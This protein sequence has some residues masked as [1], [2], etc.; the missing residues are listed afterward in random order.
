[1]II[2]ANAGL[3]M[4]LVVGPALVVALLPIV[5][6][7]AGIYRRRI[8]VPWGRAVCGSLG[9]NLLSTFVGVPLTWAVLLGLQFVTG[10]D[11]SGSGV[12]IHS[13]TWQAPWL[14]PYE[15]HLH[16]MIPTAAIVLCVP[17]LLASVLVENLFLRRIWQEQAS[18]TILRACWIANGLTYGCLVAFWGVQLILAISR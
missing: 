13:V 17:F 4:L 3:P 1:M 9:A 8:G 15:R 12:G 11:S 18:V 5:L 10:G 7:E 16:W 2:L 14:L 6:I